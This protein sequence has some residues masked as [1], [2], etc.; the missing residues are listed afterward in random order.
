MKKVLSFVLVLAMI[1]GSVSMVFAF[2]DDATITNT[3]ASKVLA[4]IGV[5]EGYA[6][7][8]FKP[9]QT[10]TR[11]EGAA[12]AARMLLGKA[13]AAKLTTVVNPFNDVKATDWCAGYIAYC[14]SQGIINGYGNGNFGPNDTLTV[15]Q[16]GKMMLTALG[17]K[18]EN[19]GFVGDAWESNVGA[20]MVKA[21]LTDGVTLSGSN[22]C[23]REVA[24]Q[25][26]LNTLKAEL[27]KYEGTPTTVSTGSVTVTTG[28]SAAKKDDWQGGDE[29]G[30]YKGQTSAAKDPVRFMNRYQKKVKYEANTEAFGRPSTYKWTYDNKKLATTKS[31]DT[32]LAS[33]TTKQS[34]KTIYDLLKTVDGTK[35]E[36]TVKIW[37]N[38]T[39]KKTVSGSAI[40]KAS[41]TDFEA[42]GNGAQIEVYY[43]AADKLVNIV[44]YDY[45]LVQAD[46]DYNA[47]KQS[48]KVTLKSSTAAVTLTGDNKELKLEDFA[49]ADVK[50]DDY[51]VATIAKNEVKSIAPANK[52]TGSTDTFTIGKD[53]T[54]DGTKYTVSKV[55]KDETVSSTLAAGTTLTLVLDPNNFVLATTDE[56]SASQFVYIRKVANKSGLADDVIADAYFIDGTKQEITLDSDSVAAA[57]A[58]GNNNGWFNY[59]VKSNGKYKLSNVG[60]NYTTYQSITDLNAGKIAFATDAAFKAADANTVFVVRKSNGNVSVYTGYKNVPGTTTATVAAIAKNNVSKYVFVEATGALTGA[61]TSDYLLVY[62][63]GTP[64]TVKSGDDT[65]YTFGK[66]FLNGTKGTTEFENETFAN[67]AAGVP[68]LYLNI[69]YTDGRVSDG[70]SIAAVTPTERESFDVVATVSTTAKVKYSNTVVTFDTAS[71]YGGKNSFAVDESAVAYVINGDDVD[72]MKVANVESNLDD[73]I[74]YKAYLVFTNTKDQIIKTL[75]IVK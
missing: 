22:A 40:G 45:F 46:G 27:V 28:Q 25:V 63:N 31:S 70:K 14:V 53:I 50:A 5:L 52:L 16:F 71:T 58:L 62:K 68:D 66:T 10:L 48:V 73:L 55:A 18:S 74:T 30:T 57:K 19:E 17:Y 35:D 47:S 20:V 7:G 23:A 8:T 51:L 15:A 37:E 33:Y 44:K 32:L 13:D 6:D 34:E 72:E 54:V 43:K 41:G 38:G 59:S 1:L 65:Y 11:A 36:A 12:I 49:V 21:G 9:T 26:A 64:S 69:S 3:E 24:A 2:T 29:Q 42:W 4:G 61:N 39:L 56:V 60:T 67:A 75:F